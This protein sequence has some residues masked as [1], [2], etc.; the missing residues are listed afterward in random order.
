[1]N[2]PVSGKVISAE[3]EAEMM[4]CIKNEDITYGK[5][6]DLF[7]MDFAKYI[8]V[9]HAFFVNSGS[10]ANLL[11]FAAFASP[12]M[13]SKWRVKR[14]DEIITVALAFPTTVAPI[15]QYGCVPVFVDVDDTYNIDPK[16]LESAYSKKTKGV[17]IAHTLGNPFYVDGVKEFCKKHDL[18]LIEDCCDS[19][20]SEWNNQ[21]CGSFGD[22]STFSFYPAHHITTGEGGMVAASDD[23]IANIIRSLRGWGKS[24]RCSPGHDNVCGKRFIGRFG[25]LPEGYDHK[26]VFSE[27]GYNLQ[28]TNILAALGW[29]QLKHLPEFTEIRH[30][31]YDKLLHCKSYIDDKFTTI[32]RYIQSNPSWF[33][34]GIKLDPNKYDRKEAIRKLNA[35]GVQ[36]RFLF[37]GNITKQP[38]FIDNKVKYRVVGDLTNTNDVMQNMFW[39]GCYH[40]LSTEQIDYEIQCLQEVLS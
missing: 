30:R 23:R 5:Y 32:L 12:N 28:G 38:M 18:F 19:L 33:G 29:M 11:A 27:I 34:F 24:C 15:I 7:E 1:M 36:T 10:S 4:S 40:G 20:G 22:V 26:Y 35:K 2:V 39:V 17:F 13:Y 25:N 6:N 21:K 37:A 8:G 14:G 9:K 16:K 31:N 3:D